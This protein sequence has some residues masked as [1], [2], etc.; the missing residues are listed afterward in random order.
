MGSSRDASTAYIKQA[1]PVVHRREAAAAAEPGP[2]SAFSP[3]KESYSL[4]ATDAAAPAIVPAAASVPNLP[5]WGENENAALDGSADVSRKFAA[6][7]AA[8]TH[9]NQQAMHQQIKL[10]KESIAQ[11]PAAQ[12][13]GDGPTIT[14]FGFSATDRDRVMHKFS[15]FGDIEEHSFDGNW[16][17]ITYRDPAQA[18]AALS[19]AGSQG[20]VHMGR[21]LLVGVAPGAVAGSG[22]AATVG[23]G[24]LASA[25]ASGPG[26]GAGDD[27]PH[28]VAFRQNKRPRLEVADAPRPA[29]GGGWRGWGASVTEYLLGP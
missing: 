16:V 29:V 4:R 2:D 15:S 8:V 6:L 17:T 22:A 18:Q 11:A 24:S 7:E 3:P 28:P 27:A 20:F 10:L 13:R 26:S 14:V 19:R 25:A 21:E 12:R 23:Q 9:M 1:R 5:R